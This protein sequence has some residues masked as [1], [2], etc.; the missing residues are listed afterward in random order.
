MAHLTIKVTINDMLMN[1]TLIV[2]NSNNAAEAFALRGQHTQLYLAG[3]DRLKLAAFFLCISSPDI[4][5]QHA[6]LTIVGCKVKTRQTKK[7]L[8]ENLLMLFLHGWQQHITWLL[9]L[10]TW[11][12][13]YPFVYKA[14]PATHCMLVR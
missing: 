5:G 8:C 6:I 14:G 11:S 9:C 13:F 12:P 10:P 1:L 3:L 2:R 7:N 4:K